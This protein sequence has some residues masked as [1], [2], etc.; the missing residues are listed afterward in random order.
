MSD[1]S[2]VEKK[3][4]KKEERKAIG[5]E[6]E[7]KQKKEGEERCATPCSASGSV[8][9]LKKVHREVFKN[10]IGPKLLFHSE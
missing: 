5:Q 4:R 6:R 10:F 7:R 3:E 9:K 8:K 1:C 2:K